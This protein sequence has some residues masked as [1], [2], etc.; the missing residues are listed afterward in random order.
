MPTRVQRRERARKYSRAEAQRKLLLAAAGAMMGL[1]SMD[2]LGAR[3]AQRKIVRVG[4]NFIGTPYVPGG[5]NLR[6]GVDCDAYTKKTF[7]RSGIRIPWGPA[8][9]AYG[10]RARRGSPQP[11]DIVAFNEHGG[12]ISHVGIYSGGGFILHA[13]S[14]FDEVVE[15]EMRYVRGHVATRVYR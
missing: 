2:E 4:R 3:G 12:G 15:S 11:G 13:S 1:W 8:N 9:Q 5:T 7:R 14:Y 10:G 6:R